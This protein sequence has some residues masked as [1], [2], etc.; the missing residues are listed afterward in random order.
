MN[1][2]TSLIPFSLL[3]ALSGCLS[4]DMKTESIG[5]R[6][7]VIRSNNQKTIIVADFSSPISLS[8]IEK[9]WHH[10]EFMFTNPMK[11]SFVNYKDIPAIRFETKNGGSMLFRHID[12]SLDEY[13]FLSNSY[14]LYVISA[15]GT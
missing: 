12:I 13:P 7:N 1:S 15:F 8:P 2:S 9:G 14:M 11:I 5:K 4:P 3:I 10:Q 6:V